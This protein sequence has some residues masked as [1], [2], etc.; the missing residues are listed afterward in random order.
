MNR[1]W[2]VAALALAPAV[3][4]ASTLALA[5]APGAQPVELRRRNLIKSAAMP[6]KTAVGTTIDSGEFGNATM[7]NTLIQ[8]GQMKYTVALAE[9]FAAEGILQSNAHR[10]YLQRMADAADAE[11]LEAAEVLANEQ[12]VAAFMGPVVGETLPRTAP[13][14]PKPKPKS[15][16]RAR[17]GKEPTL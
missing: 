6:Y 11:A 17:T 9:R 12:A 5:P 8:T 14:N 15:P 10:D 13:A 16:V 4:L 2:A 3:V 1:T 7:N